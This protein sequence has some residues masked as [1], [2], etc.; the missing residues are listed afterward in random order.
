MSTREFR[1]A[2]ARAFAGA[3]RSLWLGDK[4]HAPE[5]TQVLGDIE[6][7]REAGERFQ[8]IGWTTRGPLRTGLALLRPRL[9]DGGLLWVVL[10]DAPLLGAVSRA[11]RLSPRAD[12]ALI[13]ACEALLL[14]GYREPRVLIELRPRLVLA[15]NK[16]QRADPLDAFF[17]QP[18]P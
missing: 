8:A 1:G 9:S 11:L 3:E 18:S 10:D 15:A 14:T 4:R 2:L 7:L 17:E 12:E 16:P 13:E 6:E 5:G